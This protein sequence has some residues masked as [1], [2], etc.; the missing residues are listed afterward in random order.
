MELLDLSINVTQDIFFE[1][2]TKGHL[3]LN[4]Q[5]EIHTIV[6]NQSCNL[7]L[8]FKNL[9]NELNI[10]LKIPILLIVLVYFC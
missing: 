3:M 5:K 9:F 8:Q 10:N 2:L 4:I 6:W 1:V 7:L